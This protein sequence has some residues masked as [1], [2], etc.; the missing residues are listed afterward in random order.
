MKAESTLHLRSCFLPF[1]F[2]SSPLRAPLPLLHPPLDRPPTNPPALRTRLP[3]TRDQAG[4][5]GADGAVVGEAEERERPETPHQDGGSCYI[6]RGGRLC[7]GVVRGTVYMCMCVHVNMRHR[8]LRCV[9][10]VHT[11][12]GDQWGLCLYRWVPL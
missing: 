8:G 6:P 11:H 1:N 10:A 7:E 5:E 9:L 4:C 12:A 2:I 3:S